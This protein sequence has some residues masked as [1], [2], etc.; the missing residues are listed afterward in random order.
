MINE[1]YIIYEELVNKIIKIYKNDK[2]IEQIP[3][4]ID[5]F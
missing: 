1:T 2:K 5:N 3:K 4:K